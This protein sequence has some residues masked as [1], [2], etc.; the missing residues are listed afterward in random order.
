MKTHFVNKEGHKTEHKYANNQIPC[1]NR[2]DTCIF[3]NIYKNIFYLFI[4]CAGS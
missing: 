4:D 1:R 2:K 3:L